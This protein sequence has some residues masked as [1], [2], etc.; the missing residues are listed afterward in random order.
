[1]AS[2][3]ANANFASRY[4]RLCKSIGGAS[5]VLERGARIGQLSS[6]I[7]I[8]KGSIPPLEEN[9]DDTSTILRSTCNYLY[10]SSL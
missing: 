3:V 10:F 6:V 7:S 8:S 4:G 2:F 5:M 1:M 9:R